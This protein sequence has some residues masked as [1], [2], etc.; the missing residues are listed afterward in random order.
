M[1]QIDLVE[2]D[3]E[4]Q[5]ILTLIQVSRIKVRGPLIAR[6]KKIHVTSNG[7]YDIMLQTTSGGKIEG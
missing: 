3:H 6:V 7:N 5:K 4:I 2:L 1:R